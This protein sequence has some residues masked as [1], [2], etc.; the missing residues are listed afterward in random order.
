MLPEVTVTKLLLDSAHDAMP[1]YDHCKANNITP[2]IDLNWKC[3]RPPVY[4]D[5]PRLFSN[6]PRNSKSWKMEYNAR[7]SAERCNKREKIDYKLE[8]GRYRSSMMWYCRLFAI[9][10]CQHLDGWTLPKI[11]R[12]KDL[13][14]RIFCCFSS[15]IFCLSTCTKKA[16]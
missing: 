15:L 16:A 8:D 9:M 1:Y 3:G 4:K 14:I 5:S 13:F 7:T 10:M 6:P 12:L 11:S 2:F